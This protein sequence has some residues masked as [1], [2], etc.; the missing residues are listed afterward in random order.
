ML[1]Q[2]LKIILPLDLVNLLKNNCAHA[3]SPDWVIFMRSTVYAVQYWGIT[4][5]ARIYINPQLVPK[6]QTVKIDVEFNEIS[7]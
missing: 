5:S 7:V 2:M 4:F 6:A 3:Y 1:V